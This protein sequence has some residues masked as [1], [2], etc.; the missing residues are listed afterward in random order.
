MQTEISNITSALNIYLAK[1]ASADASKMK[2]ES[3]AVE[4][5]GKENNADKD[6]DETHNTVA[7]LLFKALH[8]LIYEW[9]GV[10]LEYLYPA[11]QFERDQRKLFFEENSD[12]VGSLEELEKVLDDKDS[13]LSKAF[14]QWK[15]D[16]CKYTGKNNGDDKCFVAVFAFV[17][18]NQRVCGKLTV[19]PYSVET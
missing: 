19:F 5:E 17:L 1:I 8:N 12:K 3:K 15:L 2:T 14:E 7:D 9:Y 13:E 18:S 10:H 6:V 11:E 16:T 4:E